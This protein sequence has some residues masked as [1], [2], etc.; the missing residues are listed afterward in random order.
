MAKPS[1]RVREQANTMQSEPHA[2]TN[3]IRLVRPLDNLTDEELMALLA[4]GHEDAL[5]PLHARYAG[6]VFGIVA[7]SLDRSA[8]EEITQDV[9]LTLWQKAHT[10]DPE[11]GHVRPWL[12]Q[13]AHSRVLNELRRRGRR[14]R[15]VPDPDETRLGAVPDESPQPDEEAWRDFRREAIAAAVDA[16][17]TAQRQALSLAYFED[18]TQQQVA[19]YLGLPLG[20]AKTRIRTG[21]QR[22]RVSLMPIVAAATLA[23]GGV[24]AALGVRYHQQQEFVQRQERALGVVASSSATAVRLTAGPGLPAAM[25]STYR[26][27]PGA[28]LAIMTFSNFT[29]APA[30]QVYQAWAGENGAWRS[31]GVI[32]LDAG[33][34]ALA[35]V[36]QPGAQAPQALQVTLEPTGGSATPTGPVVVSWS[37]S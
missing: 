13:I 19:A 22:L 6:L 4:D 16:L 21:M 25:H 17:P 29:P 8:A 32:Q 2:A 27:S 37:G 36:D 34:H 23:L 18:L 24:L 33:G 20:T 5:T 30:G 28:D 7:Q 35:I 3:P 10:Y 14:P 1:T 15:V 31:L 12:L 26:T 11:R 9:F